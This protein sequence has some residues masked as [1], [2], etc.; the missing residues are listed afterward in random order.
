[1]RALR[2]LV[3]G[4]LFLLLYINKTKQKNFILNESRAVEAIWSAMEY[5]IDIRE[6]EHSEFEELAILP[7]QEL[8]M[9]NLMITCG[10]VLTCVKYADLKLSFYKL[11]Y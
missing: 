3:I 10:Y 6:N 11:F 2:G 8:K 7:V 5:T 1:M 9:C 4:N